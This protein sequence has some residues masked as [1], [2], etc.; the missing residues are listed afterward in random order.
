MKDAYRPRALLLHVGD[1]LEAID[2]LLA[3]GQRPCMT[4]SRRIMDSTD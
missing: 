2:R 3:D 1:V 4:C